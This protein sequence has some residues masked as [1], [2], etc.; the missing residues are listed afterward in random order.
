MK[1]LTIWT[2]DET[3]QQ[4]SKAIK[5]YDIPISQVT[6]LQDTIDTINSRI[7]GQSSAHVFDDTTT[8]KN[9]LVKS[10]GTVG[11]VG[12]DVY[13]TWE[14]DDYWVA[15]VSDTAEYQVEIEGQSYESCYKLIA[16]SQ[17]T[18]DLS[19]YVNSLT[20]TA[21]NGVLTGLSKSGKILTVSSVNLTTTIN[22]VDGYY[23]AGLKQESNGKISCTTSALPTCS[24][25]TIGV[26]STTFSD[27]ALVKIAGSGKVSVTAGSNLITIGCDLS[28]KQDSLTSTQLTACNSGITSSLVSQITTNKNSIATNTSSISTTN[29]NL[30]NVTSRVTTLENNQVKI[31][32]ADGLTTGGVVTINYNV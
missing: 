11:K 18:V 10:E 9:W 31:S 13:T 4:I 15:A 3:S 20:G 32:V 14:G 17:A 29:T 26:G 27:D 21:T 2:K 7:D 22:P 23:I 28:G 5:G 12:D 25:Q 16:S 30:T 19:G 8:F 1:T 24:N 6:S